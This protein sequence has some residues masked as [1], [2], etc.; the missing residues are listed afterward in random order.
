MSR[1]KDGGLLELGKFWALFKKEQPNL[2]KIMVK[3]M[4]GFKSEKLKAA[5][6]HGVWMTYMALKSQEEADDMNENWGIK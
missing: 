3:E 2:I 4:K 1:S 6:A 5:F